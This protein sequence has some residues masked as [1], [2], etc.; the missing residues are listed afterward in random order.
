MTGKKSYEQ[1]PI[2][3]NLSQ[4]VDEAI[5]YGLVRS[6][7]RPKRKKRLIRV[8]AAAVALFAPLVLLMNFSPSFVSAVEQIP[9]LG[10]MFRIF[11]FREIHEETQY[12]YIDAVIPQ[13]SYDGN[14]EMENRV[15]LE[16]SH[17]IQEEL[18]RS[19][20]Q[21]K[22]YYDA[23]V[24]TG[25]KPEEYRP[26]VVTVDYEVK[27]I[28]DTT[29]S[30][31]ITKWETLASAYNIQYFYNIDLETG[32]NLTL[33]DCLGPDYQKIVAESIQSQIDSWSDD[34]RSML[35]L[36][37]DLENLITEK[38]NFYLD[39]EG[40][41]VVVFDKYEIAAGAAGVLE[42]PID[43]AKLANE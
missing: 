22:E 24:Q 34:M 13:I 10:Q 8:A 28:R 29:A 12:Q 21:A 23:F 41:V 7:A 26:I 14:S 20:Q 42:F 27:S 30:F 37:T 4:T 15:N 6:L 3:E 32:D 33:R 38:R 1:I 39:D 36:E 40:R 31:V 17:L 16:I 5:R 35:F 9:I 11:D 2:P 19:E 43:G 25:G 18:N